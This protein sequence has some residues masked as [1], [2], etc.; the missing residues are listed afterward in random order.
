MKLV[1]TT[2]LAL[3]LFSSAV[4]ALMKPVPGADLIH[5]LRTNPV[6]SDKF[7]LAVMRIDSMLN[8]KKPELD[9]IR[10]TIPTLIQKLFEAGQT[11]QQKSITNIKNILIKYIVHLKNPTFQ[12]STYDILKLGYDEWKTEEGVGKTLNIGVTEAIRE[13]YTKPNVVP[14]PNWVREIK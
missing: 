2:L 3:I 6:G 1:P 12:K 8:A 9:T 7:E 11:S 4:F 13:I 5:L 14:I 10:K